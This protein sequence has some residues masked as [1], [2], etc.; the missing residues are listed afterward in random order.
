MADSP[1]HRFGQVIGNIL[2]EILLPVLLRFC[3]ERNLYL[4]RH[5]DR[6]QVRKGRKVSWEDKYGNTHDLDFVIEKDG[7]AIKRGK[8]VAFIEAAW[9]RYTKHSKNKVQEIQGAVLPIAEKYDR[10]QPFLGAVLAGEF[11]KP[12]LDQLE[13]IGFEV[14]Y[15]PYETIV[16]AFT[17]V[18]I[19][20]RFDESTPDAKFAQC[21]Q[22]IEQLSDATRTKLKDTLFSLNKGAFDNFFTALRAKLDRI[23]ERVLVLPLF[24]NSISF[25]NVADATDFIAKFD[26]DYAAGEF[27]KYELIVMYSNKD[28][29][30]GIF[31][32]KERSM[33]FLRYVSG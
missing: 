26:S 3:E 7:S 15:L 5:G 11:T 17:G 19:D 23:I 20:A 6:V 8:P 32:S 2:E 29:I 4:D 12:S 28:E 9:R 25:D 30:R 33:D 21:V 10:D 1:S 16:S 22:K 13:S 27:Q 14:V 18:R 24:G 31:T